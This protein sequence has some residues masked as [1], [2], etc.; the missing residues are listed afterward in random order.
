MTG[1]ASLTSAS[2]GVVLVAAGLA[3]VVL[4]RRRRS[5]GR[6]SRLA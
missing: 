3:V 1:A 6:R 4:T 5:Q 2:I